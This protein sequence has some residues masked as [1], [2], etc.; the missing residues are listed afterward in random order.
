MTDKKDDYKEK[1]EAWEAAERDREARREE[2]KKVSYWR[3][4]VRM[5]WGCWLWI[6]LGALVGYQIVQWIF[7]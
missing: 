1:L 2:P 3:L 5:P 6:A 4:P 7:R